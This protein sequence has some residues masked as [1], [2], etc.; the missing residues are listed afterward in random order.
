MEPDAA[1]CCVSQ[2]PRYLPGLTIPGIMHE[3]NYG[4]GTTIHLEDMKKDQ[5]ALYVGVGG[6]LEALQLA[7]F[8]RRPGGVIAVDPVP[9]MRAAA[10]KNLELAA[11]ENPWFDP[12]FVKILEGDAR[13][14]PVDDDSID[15]AAQNCLFNI[16]KTGSV[17]GDLERALREM[18]RVLGAQGRLVMTDPIT[19]RPMPVHLQ[20]DEVLRAKCISGCLTYEAY[21]ESIVGAGFGQI[22]VRARVPYRML[23]RDRYKL[24]EDLLLESLEVCAFKTSIPADGP[25]IFTGRMAIYTGARDVHDDGNGHL[26]PRDIPVGVCD[27]TAAQISLLDNP[28]ITVT[29]STWHYRGGGCC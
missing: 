21:L 13:D 28:E 3:M 9:E 2:A 14:L 7:Y 8:T 27:K 11:A 10:T 19:T 1:L 18:R 20:D 4:C 17:D 5:T 12:A 6:G 15:V 29:P 22:E 23:T 25:C 24:E 26:L 16:F